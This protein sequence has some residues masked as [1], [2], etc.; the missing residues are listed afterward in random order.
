MNKEKKEFLMNFIFIAPF[1]VLLFGTLLSSDNCGGYNT[2]FFCSGYPQIL[3]HNVTYDLVFLRAAPKI[4]GAEHLSSA[5]FLALVPIIVFDLTRNGRFA[6]WTGILYALQHEGYWLLGGFIAHYFFGTLNF[7]N[8][9]Y[10]SLYYSGVITVVSFFIIRRYRNIYFTKEF[11]ILILSYIGYL[12]FWTFKN[13]F[14]ITVSGGLGKPI[15]TPFYWDFT[16]NLLEAGSWWFLG[17]GFI[18]LIIILIRFKQKG[19]NSIN[20]QLLNNSRR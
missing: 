8:N 13:G 18:I 5:L 14:E 15:L 12:V 20:N 1:C 7:Y 16:T 4:E 19:I 9:F 3:Q 10:G 2:S 6:F 17:L 11:L